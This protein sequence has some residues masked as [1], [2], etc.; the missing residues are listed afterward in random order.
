MSQIVD[1]FK[2]IGTD[3]A[4]RTLSQL[5]KFTDGQLE[6]S[7]D[8]IQWLMPLHERSYHS[9]T[10]PVLTQEDVSALQDPKIQENMLKVL[11]RF[12]HFL[13][14]DSF[15]MIKQARWCYDGNHNLLRVTRAIRSLRLFG[16]EKEAKELYNMV[17]V[18]AMNNGVNNET[19]GFW[20]DALKAPLFSSMTRR[21]LEMKKIDLEKD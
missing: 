19:I 17:L 9:K 8:S 4:G 10:A 13:G 11:K 14:I 1:F 20:Y 18:T 5:L 2:E 15:D 7:H 16:L 6:A 21:F 12:Q 3:H